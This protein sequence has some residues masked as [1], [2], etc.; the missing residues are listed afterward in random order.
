MKTL[1]IT[2]LVG[3]LLSASTVLATEYTIDPDHSSIGFKVG[4]LGIS[5]VKGQLGKFQGTFRYDPQNVKTSQTTAKIQTESINTSNKKRDDHLKSPDFLDAPKF[6]TI[7]FTSKEVQA[8]SD[9]GFKLLGDLTIRG[10]TQPVVLDVTPLGTVTDPWGNERAGFTA[11][12]KINRKDF[13]ITWNKTM[14]TGGL[15]VGETVDV[16]LEVEGIK[17]KA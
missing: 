11:T 13:G 14:D 10:I 3:A 4:H 1:G 17:K 15:V 8:L 12:T 2:L 16:E 6:P 5:S 7:E 9:K